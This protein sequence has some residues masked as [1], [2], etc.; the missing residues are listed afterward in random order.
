MIHYRFSHIFYD[1]GKPF[2]FS[3]LVNKEKLYT[4][5]Y[6]IFKSISCNYIYVYEYSKKK[7]I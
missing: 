2:M 4:R 7:I 3:R 5:M 6:G 1:Y